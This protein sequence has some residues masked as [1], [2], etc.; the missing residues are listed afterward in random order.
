[1][2]LGDKGTDD[3]PV[4]PAETGCMH[5][6]SL[7][8]CLTLGDPM[9]C[10]PPTSSVHGIL[11]ARIMEWVAM[12]SSRGS[13]R[14]RDGACVSYVSCT[15]R[16]I[17]CHQRHLGSPSLPPE[18][19]WTLPPNAGACI[20]RNEVRGREQLYKNKEKHPAQV[21]IVVKR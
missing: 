4:C 10:G 7:Q 5:A 18:I 15:G 21:F 2:W 1:M 16:R 17:L 14:P 11:Q 8:S 3:C 6:R 13:S 9:E 12:P 20:M 19:G